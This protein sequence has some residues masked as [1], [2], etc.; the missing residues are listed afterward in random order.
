MRSL[1]LPVYESK[2]SDSQF[3]C[4]CQDSTN[5]TYSCVRHLSSASDTLFCDFDDD[6]AFEEYYNIANDPYQLFNLAVSK[7]ENDEEVQKDIEKNRKW[8]E[9]LRYCQGAKNCLI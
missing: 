4:R 6:V 2:C 9:H 8:L 7:E 3:Q 5:N 1:K